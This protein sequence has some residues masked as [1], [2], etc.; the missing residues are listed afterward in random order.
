MLDSAPYFDEYQSTTAIFILM[1]SYGNG[2]YQ[3][4]PSR[5]LFFER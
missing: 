4:A 3:E 5:I 2:E 1:L